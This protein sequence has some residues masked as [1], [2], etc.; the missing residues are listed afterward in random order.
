MLPRAALRSIHSGGSWSA[1]AVAQP[2]ARL[3]LDTREA[4][5]VDVGTAPRNGYVGPTYDGTLN[6][7]IGHTMAYV[8]PGDILR[9]Y[10][11]TPPHA[12]TATLVVEENQGVADNATAR[13]PPL[14]AA[15]RSRVEPDSIA[16]FK[17]RF[18]LM[19]GTD[20]ALQLADFGVLVQV[21]RFSS[22]GAVL[23]QNYLHD[24]YNN[25][26][27]LAANLTFGPGNVVD[28]ANDGF[29][30]SYDIASYNFLEGALGTRN[31]TIADNS[32]SRVQGCGHG[33]LGTRG[34]DHVCTNMSCILSHVDGM[35]RDQ[36][37][38][39]GN[40]VSPD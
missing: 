6:P 21:D 14:P 32:F 20:G 17:V 28:R 2:L 16:I 29:H 30:V 27:R 9:L 25:V 7:H 3:A 31:I 18:R 39:R 22:A 19:D 8:R 15:L 38:E 37:H 36:V 11:V 13:L 34:C 5:I 12:F 10:N 24:S 35:F 26:G 23:R 33:R 1:A 4:W 40:S